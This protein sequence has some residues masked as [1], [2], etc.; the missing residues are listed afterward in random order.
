MT[1]FRE[2]ARPQCCSAAPLEEP[3]AV[4]QEGGSPSI[5]RWIIYFVSAAVVFMSFVLLVL[6]ASNGFREL[7][8]GIVGLIA[9]IV[10]S[11]LTASL[12]IA[13]MGL[14]FYS[15]RSGADELVYRTS[16]PTWVNREK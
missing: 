8:V 7:G 16:D 6:W 2:V 9:L 4:E 3:P 10:G 1:L 14:V 11:L 12:G 15:D 13:L 5:G